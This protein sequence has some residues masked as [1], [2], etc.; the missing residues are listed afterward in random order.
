MRSHYQWVVLNDFLRRVVGD[1]TWQSVLQPGSATAKPVVQRRVF[2]WQDEPA[3]PV[4][5][6][7]AAYRF[8][9]SMVRNDYTLSERPAGRAIPLFRA[10]G[11]AG[12]DLT[13]FRPLPAGLTIEWDHLFKTGSRTPLPSMQIDASL[14]A[15]L[16]HVPPDGAALA[17]LNLR[18]HR[19]LRLPP[20][21]EVAVAL[22][23]TPLEPAELVPKDAALA[24]IPEAVLR[25]PPL[26]YY[27][28]CEAGQRHDGTH[29][30]PVGG[31]IV[32]E[33][34]VGLVEADRNSYLNAETPWSP[35]LPL[36]AQG[37][38]TMAQL[39]KFATGA[40][41]GSDP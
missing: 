15:R 28:L 8:G 5:F 25:S 2:T 39:V 9:H 6:S 35:E 10:P 41:A 27:V 1:A 23:E 4:E 36:D 30:G 3:I 26:W 16:A 7:G 29:L 13:G 18:R 34:L 38:F 24:D 31:R 32:A 33:V 21:S 14:S 12:E 11:E 22:G 17:H 19:A 20:G 40:P 37:K